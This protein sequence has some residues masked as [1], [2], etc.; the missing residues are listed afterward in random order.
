M[1]VIRQ[2]DMQTNL[3]PL[4]GGLP[5]K[6]PGLFFP[7]RR[8]VFSTRRLVKPTRRVVNPRH[9][10]VKAWVVKHSQGRQMGDI[11]THRARAYTIFISPKKHSPLHIRCLNC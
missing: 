7:T 9:R 6:V 11:P 3:S 4:S 8:V 10:V 2:N 1:N 5:F